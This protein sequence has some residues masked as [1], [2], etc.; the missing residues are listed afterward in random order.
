[1]DRRKGIYKCCTY[2]DGEIC[3]T[4]DKFREFTISEIEQSAY[5]V[6]MTGAR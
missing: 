1:M 3:D 5:C 2:Y 4:I 6:W